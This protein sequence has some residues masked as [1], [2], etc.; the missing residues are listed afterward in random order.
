MSDE[1]N[2]PKKPA[3]LYEP[4][5]LDQ[6]R[7]NIGAIDPDEAR[8]M[9]KILGGQ[10]FTEKSQPINPAALPQQK[11][12]GGYIHRPAKGSTG[13]TAGL[14]SKPAGTH[15]APVAAAPATNNTLPD[16]KSS[17]L[18]QIEKL[19][20]SQDYRIKPNYGV[21][22]FIRYFRKNG[23]ELVRKDFI[24]QTLQDYLSYLQGFMTSIKSL[25]QI[26]PDSYKAQIQ[27][28]D[29][30]R[31]QFLRTVGSWT[32]KDIRSASD[33]LLASSD[34]ITVT[35]MIPLIRLIYRM[36]LKVYYLGEN[37]IPGI[38]KDIYNDLARYSDSDKKKLTAISKDALTQWMHVYTN[39]IKGLYPLLMRMCSNTYES[40]PLFFTAKATNILTFLGM[41][42]FELLMPKKKIRPI[43]FDDETED[44]DQPSGP[45][46]EEI[47]AAAEQA[48]RM[49]VVRSGLKLLDQLFPDA[50]FTKLDSMP[51]MYPYFQPLYQFRD[52]FNLLNPHN[53]LQITIVLLRIS[54]DIFQACRNVQ[55]TE[56]VSPNGKSDDTLGK[57]LSDWSLY[58]EVLFEKNYCEKL[59]N[60]CNEQ[61]SQSDFK[62]S[63]FGKKLLTSLLWQTKYNFLPHFKF[64][65]LLLEKPGNESQYRPMCLR[66]AFLR[67]FFG[68]LAHNIDGAAE[69][70][71]DVMGLQNPWERYEFDIPNVVSKR[72]DVL[73]GAKRNDTAATNANLVKYALCIVAVLDWWVNDTDSPAY[74]A[75]SS[76]I[77]R[78]SDS[79][80]GVQFSV[81]LRSDQNKLFAERVKA[82]AQSQ[83]RS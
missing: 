42:K 25:I 71:G 49:S 9:T 19:L 63:L 51:D 59:V 65:Q 75:D 5:T 23:T 1:F 69:T 52:G 35:D 30:E 22:N 53:P 15:A 11:N 28:E 38:L 61:Y 16:I 34:S 77:Y 64:T 80:G 60:F 12:R 7:K 20:M 54:E 18:I 58:R 4:G 41:T 62:N 68:E 43:E 33:E 67:E 13:G 39:L 40:F 56:D 8:R 14:K 72:M 70:K 2:P 81:P 37:R 83:N 76:R 82:A 29:A 21:F 10:I 26:S 45:T 55:F 32:M 6:T 78:I 50:G 73:L 46:P 66:A 31:F 48:S 79:D 3:A 47:Q 27:V 24:D 74:S 17:E 44:D 57:T 36:V